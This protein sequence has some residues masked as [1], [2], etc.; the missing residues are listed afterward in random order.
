[1]A[2][3][4]TPAELD[5]LFTLKGKGM[6][7]VDIHAKLEAKRANSGM[8]APSLPN[9]RKVLKGKTYNRGGTETRG[10]RR[11]L[12]PAKIRKI[13]DTRKHLILK[14]K[15]EQ[16]ITWPMVLRAS[17]VKCDP[18]TA[19]KSL[20]AA[21]YD[22]KARKHRMKPM[23]TDEAIQHRYEQCGR[24]RR[25]P[26]TYWDETL[27]FIMDN[28]RWEVPTYDLAK[29]AAKLRKPRFVLRTRS[30]GLKK[31]FTK[32]HPKK[33]RTNPGASVSVVAG[34][35]RGRVRVWHYLDKGRWNGEVA[36][37]VYADPIIKCLRRNFPDKETYKIL[38]DND[39]SGYKS[40][41]ALDQKKELKI[42]TVDLPKYSPDLNPCDYFLWDEIERRMAKNVPKG[43]E[44]VTAYK[45]RL[46]S[47]AM[48]IPESVIRKGVQD[49]KKRT[50]AV[51][52]AE[53]NDIAK[54]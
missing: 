54:D 39:P 16:E 51:W 32:P 41:K 7:P 25:C 28:K 35:C 44:S 52:E 48:A 26:A 21:G 12:T 47:T 17:R 8:A 45:A 23:R 43:R 11:V 29:R 19:A 46:R 36:A 27:D 30:E 18:T 37:N 33:H 20:Q 49:M 1:M 13:F 50:Q 10:R 42:Q 2:P 6:E 3:H 53:G 40:N 5:W 34:I 22:V 4:L 38:E 9:L 15:G 24:W 31:G 14:H